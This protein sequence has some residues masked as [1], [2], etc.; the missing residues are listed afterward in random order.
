MHLSIGESVDGTSPC[1]QWTWSLGRIRN[2][3]PKL[4]IICHV[5]SQFHEFRVTH[6]HFISNLNGFTVIFCFCYGQHP[7][8]VSGYGQHPEH[9]SS[10]TEAGRSLRLS[11]ENHIDASLATLSKACGHFRIQK[12]AHPHLPQYF[13][14]NP[15]PFIQRTSTN[16]RCAQVTHLIPPR[17]T[18]LEAAFL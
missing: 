1:F 10:L 12:R 16:M 11:L 9:V 13:I 4:R 8:H 18:C 7:E 5:S 2:L 6:R 3:C 14:H 15:D 17:G